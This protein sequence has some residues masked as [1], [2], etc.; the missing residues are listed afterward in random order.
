LT[1][2][3]SGGLEGAVDIF[4]AGGRV[5]KGIFNIRVV[6]RLWGSWMSCCV[7]GKYRYVLRTML[8]AVNLLCGTS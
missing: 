4:F 2:A 3:S 6:M 7:M 8:S 1:G 5:V